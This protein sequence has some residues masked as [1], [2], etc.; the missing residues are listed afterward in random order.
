MKTASFCSILL[1]A[2]SSA[3]SAQTFY[4]IAGGL[5]YAGSLPDANQVPSEHYTRGFAV[6]GSVGR[7]FGDRFAVR[8]DAF[9]NHF[10]VQATE[11]SPELCPVGASCMPNQCAIGVLCVGAQP[12]TL[13]NSLGVTALRANAL[14]T[15]DPRGY[16]ARMYLIAGA[17]GYYFYQHPSVEGAVRVGLS[18]GAGFNIRVKGRSQV[19]IE[20]MYDKIIGAPGEP[21]WLLPFTVGVRF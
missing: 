19:F 5:N 18:A 13:T 20:G 14:L 11:L 7:Q 16:T 15:V 2:V 1:F 17:G 3:L 9:V 12:H 10:A 21:T 6:Q 8:L 4:G